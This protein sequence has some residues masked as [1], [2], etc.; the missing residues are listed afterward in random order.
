MKI[1]AWDPGAAGA[2][3]VDYAGEITI[4]PHDELGVDPS[5]ELFRILNGAD[6]FCYESQTGCAG[7]RV[8][9]PAM[10]KFGCNYMEVLGAARMLSH[11]RKLTGNPVMRMLPVTP[12]VWQ[13]TLGLD[14]LKMKKVKK[15]KVNEHMSP[16]EK[17]EIEMRCRE[18]DKL[19]SGA[20]YHWKKTLKEEA[21]KAFRHYGI[22]ITMEN[23]DAFLLLRYAWKVALK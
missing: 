15:P 23:C 20:K 22:R 12:Q 19:N 6:V 3:L 14:A 5:A 16:N 9:A 13:K 2:F 7:I 10:F 1:V 4:T 17:V 11:I 18:I 21:D 8:S